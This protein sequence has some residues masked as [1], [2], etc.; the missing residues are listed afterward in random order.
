AAGPEGVLAVHSLSKR[1]NFA[2]ARAGFYAGDP[3]L[4][5][6]LSELRKRAGLMVPGPVQD[7]AVAAYGDMAHVD[8]QRERY[9][10]RLA[11]MAEALAGGGGGRALPAG[12]VYPW[13]GG[14]R[15]G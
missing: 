13:V 14:A 15:G 1:S 11:H 2:G 12:G 4:V 8:E 9:R 10:A 6:Y 7:A 3:E 5:H